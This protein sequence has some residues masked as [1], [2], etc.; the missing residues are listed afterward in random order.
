MS[1]DVPAYLRIA[2]DLRLAIA[3][4]TLPPGGKLPTESAL[5]SH[6]D[7]S[8]TVAKYAINVLKGEGLVEGRQGS[9]VYV[10]VVR[11]LV[12]EGHRRDQRT[13]PGPTSP[14]QRDAQRAGHRGTWDHESEHTEAD[15]EI[16]TRL[17]VEPGTPL[18]RT[19]YRF[20][21]DGEPIQLSTSWEPLSLTRGTPVEWPEDGSAIGVV[22]R[23]DAIGI[24]ITE[25]VERVS[26]RPAHGG[27]IEAL[28]LPARGGQLL[29]IVRTYLAGEQ[30][31]ETADIRF[32]ADRYELVFH[33][34]I[35]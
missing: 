27:E 23:F 25:S 21:A 9:G 33:L 20:L 24:R 22:A 26:T 19:R 28:N 5:M 3:S 16:A 29:V 17:A 8:R 13:Q 35:D 11:K 18:M 15:P 2:A 4:G 1:A 10:R 12:R 30:P 31:V 32:P 34:P 7:V 14:F 6:Y